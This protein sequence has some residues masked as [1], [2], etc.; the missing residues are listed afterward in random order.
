MKTKQPKQPK[1][2]KADFARSIGITPQNLNYHIQSG[3][4]P[5]V[6]DVNAWAVYL[7]GEG[8]DATL[9]KKLRE[10]IANARLQLLNETIRKT[11]MENELKDGALIEFEYVAKF[12]R[13]FNGTL[14]FGELQRLA[15]EFPASLKGKNELEI[16]V[17][18]E[19]QI[20]RIKQR[21][22]AAEEAWLEKE[23]RVES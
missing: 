2:S 12:I 6:G 3:K 4:A 1:I 18:V 20:E 16:K 22:D 14:Y 21:L 5:P 7:A 13:H 9:P 11:K 23:G 19:A 15:A 8:R 17:E 10:A